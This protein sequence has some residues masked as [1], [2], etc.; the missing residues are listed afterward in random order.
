MTETILPETD[1]DS[2]RILTVHASKGLEFPVAVV[3]GTTSR[4]NRHMQRT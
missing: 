1:D 2:V 3:S 4:L